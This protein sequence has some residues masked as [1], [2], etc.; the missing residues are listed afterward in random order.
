MNTEQ[1][2]TIVI[3]AA[4]KNSRFF[5]LN[6]QTHKGFITLHGE[7]IVFRT[8]RNL[9]DHGFTNIVMV[10]SEKDFD[11]NGLSA[12]VSK[13]NLALDITWVLQPTAEGSGH[14]LLLAKE[15]LDGDCIV[16][17]PYY[18]NA[19]ELAKKLWNEQQKSNSECVFMGTQ[20]DN[21]SLYGMFEFASDDPNRVVG[22]IEKPTQDSPSNYKINSVYL[23]SQGFLSHL[24][25]TPIEEYSLEAA[26]TSYARE[27]H[28][29]WIENTEELPSL[30]FAWDLLSMQ[31]HMFLHSSTSIS[32]EATV[33]ST[34]IIDDSHGPVVISAGTRVGDYAKI[35]G[36]CY[37]GEN[38][39]VGDYSFVRASSVEAN[40]IVGAKTEVVRSIILEGASI[41]F[42]YMA[43]SIL[44]QK[45][46]VGAG[47]ITANKRFDR[48]TIHTLLK[49]KMVA[50]DGNSHG[51]I[52]GAETHLGIGTRTMPGVLI[53]AQN[54][55]NPATTVNKNIPHFTEDQGSTNK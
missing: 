47:L 46:K 8:L 32:S 27:H 55:I 3:Q 43:D 48:Q 25:Q 2:P 7:P 36:P 52:V 19:G 26:L 50:M 14:A 5:P 24:E 10:V 35:A 13:A 20:V 15:H 23:L 38:S 33:A 34:A 30:K 49:E 44:G 1:Q 4:G 45:V 53:G 22:I 16:V 17:S 51:V 41:H 6:T 54:K 12:L 42:G 9:K 11:G 18:T 40:A 21:P 31:N 37:L 39:L 29:T 28:T